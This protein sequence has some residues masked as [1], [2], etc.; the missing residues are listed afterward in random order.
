[1]IPNAASRAL[2]RYWWG[3]SA[4]ADS[5]SAGR[6][7]I[8]PSVSSCV[9]RLFRRASTEC[10]AKYSATPGTEAASDCKDLPLTRSSQDGSS[11]SRDTVLSSRPETNAT[12]DMVKP[13]SSVTFDKGLGR[14]QL[15]IDPPNLS[16]SA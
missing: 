2:I 3:T 7:T 16:H 15:I 4:A 8:S 1:M 10:E 11:H 9:T 5:R 14:D 6:F 13:A 12:S